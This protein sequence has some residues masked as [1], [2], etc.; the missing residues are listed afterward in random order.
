MPG[1][2]ERIENAMSLERGGIDCDIHPAVP[3]MDALLP[4]LGGHWREA[5]VQRGVHELN[6]IAYPQHAPLSARPD[7]RT[8]KE[9]PGSELESVRSQ[10]LAPF[11]TSIAIC[12][13][14]YGVHLL[15]SEDMAAAFAQALN[16][17]IA[18]EWLDREPRLRSSIV[19]PLQNPE[20]A[21]DEI[22]RRAAD[23]R[24]VQ[25]LV[26]AMGEVPLGKRAYW[27]VYAA[28]ERHA[29]PI[30]IHAGSAYRHPVTSVGWP[31]YYTEDYAAQAVAFQ[32]QLTSL[33][34]EGVF[35]K[36]PNLRVVLAES[37][38]TW[39]PAYLW[40]LTKY[41][42]G[43]RTEIPWT[44]VAPIEIVRRNVRFT[45]QP[46]DAPPGN[47]FARILDHIGCDE[48]LLFSTDYPHWQFDGDAV[49]PEAL[50]GDL[51]RKIMIENPRQTYP[52]L[53]KEAVR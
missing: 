16:D 52:R 40:R 36:F 7:W 31:S 9:R 33:I 46:V 4:Y 1:V 8:G 50:P 42:R 26:P 25:V 13:C 23:R 51:V 2:A 18:R 15:F 20:M 34:C 27:P 21:V 45:L 32:T 6:S 22:E 28:A 47:A 30:C 12:N 53:L 3:G 39:L 35:S 5:V 24:F 41:W 29:L 49:L 14:L 48:L 43:L 17:W 19:V 37:G 11:G 10:A 38:I 44:D